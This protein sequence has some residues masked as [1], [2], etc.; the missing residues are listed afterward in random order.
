[1]LRMTLLVVVFLAWHFARFQSKEER[2]AFSDFLASVDAG[3]V[4]S[5]R[6][7]VLNGGPGA[8]LAA[9]PLVAMDGTRTPTFRAVVQGQWFVATT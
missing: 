4:S 2:M 5:V 1:M 6:I 9:E 3:E 7:D 8:V